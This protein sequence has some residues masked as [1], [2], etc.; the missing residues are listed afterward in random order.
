MKLVSSLVVF[1]AL[2]GAVAPSTV[3]GQVRLQEVASGFSQPVLITHAGDH[4]LFIVEKPGAIRIFH[5]ATVLPIPFLDA[6]SLINSESERGFL[7]LA[8]HP[9]FPAVPYLFVHFTS[10]GTAL[11]DGTSPSLGE[12]LI[13]RYRVSASDPNVVDPQSAKVLMRID[14]PYTSHHGGMLAFGP[15]G[16]LYIAKGDGGSFNDPGNRAQN[17]EELLGKILRVNVDQNLST[18]PYYSIPPTNP[19]AFGP[20][21]DEIFVLGL[22]NPWRF[23]FDR[24]TGDMWIGDV[25]ENSSEEV[26]RLTMNTAAPG[27]NF[28]WRI[29]EGNA[30]TGLDPC[31][32][33]AKYVA[34]YI[35]YESGGGAPRC[36]VTGGYVYRGSQTPSLSGRYV[37]ADFC[38][39]EII[40]AITN[41]IYVPVVD[42]DEMISSFGENRSGE[43]YVAGLV[44]GKIFKLLPDPLPMAMIAGRVSRVAGRGVSI[45]RVTRRT[46]RTGQESVAWTNTFGY[47]HFPATN[48]NEEYIITVAPRGNSS[49]PAPKRFVLTD[50]AYGVDFQLAGNTN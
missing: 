45:A 42:T 46:V 16:Y 22:R 41:G 29:Y 49:P 32:T 13:V 50:D 35:V 40:S 20:G 26:N 3:R 18:P 36:S 11:P 6:S 1:I 2:L 15:D 23:S 27:S 34:P 47:Y 17:I 10:N 25:G 24:A 14:Q 8:F 5:A 12:D 43:L 44:S 28:G 7:G 30:C 9:K 39:G 48:L 31:N 4:R 38:T 19:F 33:P 37:Y 21:R